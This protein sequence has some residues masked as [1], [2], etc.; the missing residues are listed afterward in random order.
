MRAKETAHA[1]EAM[2]RRTHRVEARK[3]DR[4]LCRL[5]DCDVETRV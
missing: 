3:D 5:N 1:V 2:I 4:G